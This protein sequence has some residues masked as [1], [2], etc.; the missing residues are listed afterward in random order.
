[1]VESLVFERGWVIF[2]S[3][4]RGKGG[5]STNEFWH[6]KTRVPGLSRGVVCVILRLAVLIQHRRVTRTHDD[7]YYS[8]IASTVWV[9]SIRP[10]HGRP[11]ESWLH[12]DY[13]HGRP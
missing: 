8:R 9:K 6:Q 2:S 5:S 7:G 12:F 10:S 1:M 4:F 11:Y 3:N 13:A